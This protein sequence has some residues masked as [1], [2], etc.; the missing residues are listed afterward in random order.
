MIRVRQLKSNMTELKRDSTTILFSYETPVAAHIPGK[1][2]YRT[3]KF[4]SVTTSRHINFWLDG[5]EA[6]TRPQE[7]FNSFLD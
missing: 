7:F 6:K 5:A 4:W 1:G 3:E 2:Y